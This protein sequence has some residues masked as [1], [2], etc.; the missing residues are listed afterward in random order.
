MKSCQ[1]AKRLRR[2]VLRTDSTHILI[3]ITICQFLEMDYT[4]RMLNSDDAYQIDVI[5]SKLTRNFAAT[6]DQVQ[7]ELVQ[8]LTE[9]IP[10]DSGGM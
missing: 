7:D 4:L 9:F 6:F 1:H 3:F 2:C 10:M 8:S 5:R